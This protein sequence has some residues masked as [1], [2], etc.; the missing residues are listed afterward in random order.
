M[1]RNSIARKRFYKEPHLKIYQL[2]K[3]KDEE[4]LWTVLQKLIDDEI[5]A[6]SVSKQAGKIIAT[7][8]TNHVN[9]L[10][11][12]LRICNIDIERHR[13]KKH[14]VKSSQTPMKLKEEID[15]DEND[16]PIYQ[17]RPV[18]VQ[19]F[20]VSAEME[21]K[22]PERGIEQAFDRFVEKASQHTPRY[23]NVQ[24]LQP[25]QG[26]KFAEISIYDLHVGKLTWKGETGANYDTKIA[27]NRFKE[28]FLNLAERSLSDG[29]DELVIPI[30]NDLIN[31]DT[32]EGNTKNGTPQDID[33]RWQYMID[34][35][36]GA[37]IDVIDWVAEN[38]NV[39]LMY[40]PGNHDEQYSYFITKYLYAWYRNHSNVTIDKSPTLTKYYENGV[41]LIA[42]NHFK[43]IKPKA[44]PQH[45]ATSVPE[46]WARCWYREAHGGHFHTRKTK[47]VSVDTFGGE[48]DGVMYRVL[49]SLCEEDAWHTRKGYTGNI[50]A[51]QALVYDKQKGFSDL[52]QYN[53]QPEE[54]PEKT[55]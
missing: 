14:K 20:H 21:E 51:A 2:L 18:K 39:H 34:K 9:D 43:D 42:Y 35:T 15:R 32:P 50:K 6:G 23:N 11:D 49:P 25:K 12:L 31:I 28:S 54:E 7:M 40:V 27:L 53:Q 13:I 22:V 1:A 24:S 29:C 17:D 30:G 26:S 37:F 44:M 55:V 48:T 16:N 3:E 33:S 47:G 5:E 45:M 4:Y 8:E 36:E 52:H 19:A 41:N 46:K 38:A 10:D